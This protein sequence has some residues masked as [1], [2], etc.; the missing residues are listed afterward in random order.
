M[1]HPAHLADY[2][3]GSAVKSEELLLGFDAREMNIKDSP[4][5][6]ADRRNG[7]LFRADVLKPFSTDTSVWPSILDDASRPAL[8]VGYQDLWNDLGCL[9]SHIPQAQTCQLIA[10]ALQLT[11]VDQVE[12]DYWSSAIPP[13]IPSSL[14]EDWSFLGYDIS[15]RWLLSG[16]TNCGFLPSL[17]DAEALK[18]KWGRLLNSNHL[19]NSL[20][21]ALEF[22]ALSDKRAAEHA[23][24]FV[25][26]IWLVP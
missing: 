8:C 12:R 9:R 16:L 23:P 6:D 11:N 10:V 26:G 5:W 22:A 1:A 7:Y 14:G 2:Y 21:Y 13:T 20:E 4:A 17:D 18:R 15:D 3:G 19:F 24:F 25:F